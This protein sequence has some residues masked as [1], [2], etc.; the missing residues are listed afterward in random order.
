MMRFMLRNPCALP[1]GT[2][3][4]QR[5]CACVGAR[6]RVCAGVSVVCMRACVRACVRAGVCLHARAQS[7]VCRECVCV[8]V[9]VCAHVCACVCARTRV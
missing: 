1:C 8:C 6:A 3:A 5:P 2:C 4:Q 7:L 9:R